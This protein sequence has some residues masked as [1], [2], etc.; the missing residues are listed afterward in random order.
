MSGNLFFGID[1]EDHHTRINI[2]AAINRYQHL[3]PRA[4]WTPASKLH[5]TLQFLGQVPA[6]QSILRLSALT[7]GQGTLTVLGANCFVGKNGP[8]VL[9]A[10]ISDQGF[11]D[12]VRYALGYKGHFNAHL[13]LAKLEAPGDGEPLFAGLA[14][15]MSETV[16]G[17][18]PVT[19]VKLYQTTPDGYK[20]IATRN[21]DAKPYKPIF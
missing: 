16:F 3:V 19:T 14:D 5:L 13:T 6:E 9:Y 4:T 8:R 2:L 17:S 10:R 15:E 20:T 7:C 1:I 12:T 18:S 21:L 11:C